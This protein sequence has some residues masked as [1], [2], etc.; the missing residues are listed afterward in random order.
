[1]GTSYATIKS[2]VWKNYSIEV[3]TSLS[4]H[5]VLFAKEDS[6]KNGIKIHLDQ[7]NIDEFLC[8]IECALRDKNIFSNYLNPKGE[9]VK[10]E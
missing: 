6:D 2:S 3:Y 1:M 9:Y 8:A 4:D 5:I 10:N 7:E